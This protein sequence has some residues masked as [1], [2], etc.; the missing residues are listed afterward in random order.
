MQ[1]SNETALSLSPKHQLI[2]DDTTGGTCRLMKI[3][4]AFIIAFSIYSR[5]PMPQFKW[6]EEDMKYNLC[7]LPFVGAVIGALVFLGGMVL[8]RFEI[9]LVAMVCIISVIPLIIT[10]GFHVDGFLD[11]TDALSSFKPKEEKLR[12]LKDP[13]IG[14]FAV[15]GFAIYGLIWIASLMIIC[16]DNLRYDSIFIAA[17]FV[18]ARIMTAISSVA[19]KKAKDNGMLANET[20]KNGRIQLVIMIAELMAVLAVLILIDPFVTII[21][22]AVSGLFFAY[23]RFKSY[24]EFG[25]VTGDTAGYYVCVSELLMMASLAVCDLIR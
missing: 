17:V 14:A 18:L 9:P 4:K 3:I 20:R 15:T 11:V 1:S 13:H 2:T 25:G 5:I 23:Y 12:I 6:E 16:D 10:G 8:E 7:F 24:K 21:L 22:A 19:L